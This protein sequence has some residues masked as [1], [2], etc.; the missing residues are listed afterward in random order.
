MRRILGFALLMFSLS[1]AAALEIVTP[2]RAIPIYQNPPGTFFQGKGEQIGM[3]QPNERC[4][5]LQRRVVPV[6]TR[7]ELWL[8]IRI[9]RGTSSIDGWIFAGREGSA[10]SNVKS[11]P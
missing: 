2:I 11:L 9:V 6:P 10:E 8:R 1:Y 4:E 7:S 5:V 3:A